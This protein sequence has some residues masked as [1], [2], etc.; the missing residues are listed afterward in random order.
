M[1]L[2]RLLQHLRE[3]LIVRLGVAVFRKYLREVVAVGVLFENVGRFFGVLLLMVELVNALFV[4]VVVNLL[5][6][7]SF[8]GQFLRQGGLLHRIAHRNAGHGDDVLGQL[9]RL[10]K[11]IDVVGDGAQAF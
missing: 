5:M 9:Q 8:H 6:D 11:L 1:P 3:V 4:V 7:K 10:H 2:Q